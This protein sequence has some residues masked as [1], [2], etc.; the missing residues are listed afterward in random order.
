MSVDANDRGAALAERLFNGT[1]ATMETFTVHLGVRLGLYE[2]LRELG[3]A[4]PDRLAAAAGVHRRYAREWLEQQA[5]AGIINADKLD[6]DPYQVSYRL[7]DEHVAVLLDPD[8]PL[9]VAPLAT[10][11]VGIAGALPALTEAFRTGA[12]VPYPAY[13]ADSRTGIAGANRPLYR[14]DLA[15]R[16]LAAL[17]DIRQRLVA[18]GRV[19]DLGCGEGWSSIALAQAFPQSRVDGI[20]LDE[21]SVAEARRNAQA[22]GLADRLS[23]TRA[24]A[25][26]AP[27]SGY[28]LVC[29]FEA[30]HDMADPVGVLA[31]VGPLLRPGGAV[32]IG[33]EKVA[34]AFS[35][36]GDELERLNYAFSVLHCLPATRAEGAT[37]EAGTVLREA[38]VRAYA[39]RAG[40]AGCRVLPIEHDLW[41]FYRLDTG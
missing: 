16:W 5:V 8:S 32:L 34:E 15:D 20:D 11:M 6:A 24:N 4:T 39:E 38:T 17:P 22:Q 12:G 14:T 40:Y 3:T 31:A 27:G 28:D 2:R 37:V 7:P 26:A 30:L 18:G 36:P 25:A 10:F 13:G 23:F 29:I 21:D 41:R 35:P 9:L 33:D 19:L 1:L